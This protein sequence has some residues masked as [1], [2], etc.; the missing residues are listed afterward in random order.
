MQ[1]QLQT[2]KKQRQREIELKLP[3]NWRLFKKFARFCL[4][5][6]TN[7]TAAP[8]RGQ[9]IQQQCWDVVL[10]TCKQ[11]S[12]VPSSRNSNCTRGNGRVD[13]ALPPS[14]RCAPPKTRVSAPFLAFMAS[15]G[16]FHKIFLINKY[17]ICIFLLFLCLLSAF[18]AYCRTASPNYKMRKLAPK[19]N[20]W[21]IQQSRNKSKFSFK[22][23]FPSILIAV[24]TVYAS[25]NS[26]ENLQLVPCGAKWILAVSEKKARLIR[27]H[28]DILQR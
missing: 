8:K 9:S 20:V 11:R 19:N 23:S 14:A 6:R 22:H 25:L 7:K 26:N 12:N 2:K 21:P 17:F 5:L 3:R 18:E 27:R 13:G 10:C 15:N 16:G 24:L 1:M 28:V 4:Y